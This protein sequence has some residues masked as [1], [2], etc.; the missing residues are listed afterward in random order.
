MSA[1]RN[2]ILH[3]L[4]QSKKGGL[5]INIKLRHQEEQI[6]TTVEDIFEDIIIVKQVMLQGVT[7]PRTSFYIDEFESVRCPRILYNAPLYTNLR[8]ISANI[9]GMSEKM[10]KIA[11]EA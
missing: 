1:T 4:Q 10:A 3:T 5:T 7:M 6:V 8:R 9:K 11:M 2:E